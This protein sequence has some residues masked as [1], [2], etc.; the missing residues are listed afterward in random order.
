M[1]K[2]TYVPTFFLP[3]KLANNICA[4]VGLIKE[5]REEIYYTYLLYKQ[6][7]KKLL[8]LKDMY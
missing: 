5:P 6:N 8:F 1:K 3:S 7:T 2:H 4:L